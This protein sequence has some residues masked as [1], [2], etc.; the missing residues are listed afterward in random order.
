M[1]TWLATL[2]VAL[3]ASAVLARCQMS[4]ATSPRWS[5]YKYLLDRQDRVV[6]SFPGE[7]SPQ[8]ERLI[9][10]IEALL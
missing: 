9:V 6:A 4:A 10:A 8:D 5:F 1:K 3:L 7:V 2:A